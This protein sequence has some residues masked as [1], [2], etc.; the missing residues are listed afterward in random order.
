[1][2][3]GIA[4]LCVTA[5]CL[6]LASC[7]QKEEEGEGSSSQAESVKDTVSQESSENAGSGSAEATG[8]ASGSEEVPAPEGWS[9]EMEAIK[10]AVVDAVGGNYFPNMMI[11]AELLGSMY[12][13]SSDLYDD[14][15]GE[16]PMISANVDAL[17]VVK[18]KEGK[19][20]D[21]ED[22]LNAYRDSLVNSTMQYPSNI[23]KIQASAVQTYGNYVCFVMLGGDITEQEAEGEEAV[24]TFCQEQNQLALDAIEGAVVQ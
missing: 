6:S 3:K 13:V 18:A 16:M 23:G 12:G 2:K 10:K 1:M 4:L 17:V 7:G 11:D 22:A 19:A 8:E 14:Y 21:V 9:G 15:M 20:A 5:M 24:I